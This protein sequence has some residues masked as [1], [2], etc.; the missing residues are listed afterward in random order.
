MKKDAVDS[1]GNTSSQSLSASAVERMQLYI[2]LQGLNTPL[3]F[4]NNPAMWPK[5]THPL[6]DHGIFQTHQ[7]QDQHLPTDPHLQQL[8]IQT[9]TSE[10]FPDMSL[11]SNL[12]NGGKVSNTAPEFDVN[13]LNGFSSESTS[14]IL[15]TGEMND[16]FGSA[17][18][19]LQ[20]ELSE[21]FYGEK[22]GNLQQVQVCQ[23]QQQEKLTDNQDLDCWKGMLE[24]A[25]Y[26]NM[27]ISWW[28][29]NDISQKS[30][31]TSWDSNHVDL[32]TE[33]IF[34]DFNWGTM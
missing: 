24:S 27:N 6:G 28:A 19:R 14:A 30:S 9:V 17:A 5:F 32:P 34:Q 12:I 33:S 1:G 13:S 8:P 18:A 11:P 4:Y 2:Q 23:Q 31:S 22:D 16:N 29:N 3:S 26:D 25:G 20:E 10:S 21:L 7:T 15:T